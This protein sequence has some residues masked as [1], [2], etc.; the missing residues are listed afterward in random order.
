MIG[1]PG[2]PQ[3]HGRGTSGG[4]VAEGIFMAMTRDLSNTDGPR[5]V[6]SFSTA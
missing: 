2:T 4:E 3:H 1:A 5:P 6:R